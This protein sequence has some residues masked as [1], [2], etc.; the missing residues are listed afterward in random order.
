MKRPA[1]LP[2]GHTLYELRFVKKKPVVDGDKCQ[3]YCDFKKRLIVIWENPNTEAMRSC[4][5]HEFLHAFFYEIGHED[6]A[7]DHSVISPL[8]MAIMRLR[9]EVPCL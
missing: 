3:G 4:I 9:L 6:L 8:E 1:S 2:V 7:E 5:Y